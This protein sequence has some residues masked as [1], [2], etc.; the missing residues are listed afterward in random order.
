MDG[1]RPPAKLLTGWNQKVGGQVQGLNG[2]L[3]ADGVPPAQRY[4]LTRAVGSAE[5]GKPV[6]LPRGKANRKG[7]R[8]GCGYRRREQAKAAP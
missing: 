8:W 7:R 6:A 3:H 1:A 4:D 5:R 2:P